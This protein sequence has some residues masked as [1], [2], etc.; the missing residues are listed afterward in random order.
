MHLSCY[1]HELFFVVL[2]LAGPNETNKIDTANQKGVEVITNLNDFLI[3]LKK[4][5]ETNDAEDYDQTPSS[6]ATVDGRVDNQAQEG[7]LDVED[8]D[9]DD[10]VDD[11]VEVSREEENY[12]DIG[13]Q[14]EVD[15]EEQ[16][17]YCND[18][19]RCWD[20]PGNRDCYIEG[21][22]GNWSGRPWLIPRR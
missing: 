20:E 13:E 9:D 2:L 19:V 5:E 22:K 15:T 17:G 4:P 16:V 7:P 12:D 1:R 10:R 8:D 3:R 18:C 21:C 11:D 6:A 14:D